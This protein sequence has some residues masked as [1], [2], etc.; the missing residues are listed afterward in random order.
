MPL[1][2]ADA[3]A[4]GVD[5][6]TALLWGGLASAAGGAMVTTIGVLWKTFRDDRAEHAKALTQKDKD[7]A[8][9]RKTERDAFNLR[10]EALRLGCAEERKAADERRA[11][12]DKEFTDALREELCSSCQASREKDRRHS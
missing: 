4:S 2:L 1:W 12:R 5:S 7:H 6:A 8:E 3:A 10:Y 11:A 9:E